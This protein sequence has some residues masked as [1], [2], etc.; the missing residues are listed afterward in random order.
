MGREARA[1]A[2][3]ATTWGGGCWCWCCRCCWCWL[4]CTGLENHTHANYLT[5][6][7]CVLVW[8]Q[9]AG[10]AWRLPLFLRAGL[11]PPGLVCLHPLV[12][13]QRPQAT[14]PRARPGHSSAIPALPPPPPNHPPEKV[15]AQSLSSPV[16][17]YLFV[18]RNHPRLASLH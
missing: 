6:S 1:L 13:P 17:E 3:A 8:L 12:N 18:P 2:W 5:V 15:P 9:V 14:L 11:A 7:S 4:G 10:Q 16:L